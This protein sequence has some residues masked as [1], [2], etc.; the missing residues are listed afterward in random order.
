MPSSFFTATT[1]ESGSDPLKTDPKPP[2]P[3]LCEKFFVA[4]CSSPY[5]NATRPPPTAFDALI[6]CLFRR[7]RIMNHMMAKQVKTATATP[8]TIQITVPLL[9]LELCSSEAARRR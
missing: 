2:P 6:I 3:S 1:V 9:L 8:T 5:L 4:C 7:L